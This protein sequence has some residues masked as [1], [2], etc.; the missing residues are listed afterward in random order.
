MSVVRYNL[1]LFEGM[2]PM[3]Y[4]PR[5]N[6]R[7]GYENIGKYTPEVQESIRRINEMGFRTDEELPQW[8]PALQLTTDADEDIPSC[9]GIRKKIMGPRSGPEVLQT[10]PV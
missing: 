1:D 9:R 6:R 5:K 7:K 3:T 4:T 2:T 10:F 8:E